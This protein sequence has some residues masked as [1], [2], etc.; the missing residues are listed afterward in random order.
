MN[1][2]FILCVG[3]LLRFFY[4]LFFHAWDHPHEPYR[5]LEPIAY[6]SRY[7]SG[8]ST[9][10]IWEWQKQILFW[11]PVY[12]GKT[13]V[14]FFSFFT[15]N[16]NVHFMLFKILL[17]FMSCF[18]IWVVYQWLIQRE[19][20]NTALLSAGMLAIFPTYIFQS[21]KLMDYNLEFFMTSFLFYCFW[22]IPARSRK[23]ILILLSCALWISFV[24]ITRIQSVF[25]LV[26]IWFGLIWSKQYKNAIAL[27][28]LSLLLVLLI[29]YVEHQLT[30]QGFLAPLWNNLKFHVLEHG[31]ETGWGVQKW[32][33]YFTDYFKYFGQ[34]IWLL[35]P[36]LALKEVRARLKKHTLPLSLFWVPFLFFSLLPHKEARFIFGADWVLVILFGIIASEVAQKNK[37]YRK[38]IIAFL[39]LSVFTS[40]YVVAQLENENS[41]YKIYEPLE[42]FNG[43]LNKK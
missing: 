10:L 9:P 3:F 32:H 2:R 26:P 35:L 6:L 1:I 28:V 42:F 40:G 23:S 34:A 11:F 43:P 39:V 14:T 19:Q 18:P 5:F 37:T 31:A 36:W 21:T 33:R 24:F 29:A 7:I 41:N 38:S 13:L 27:P 12:A 17:V 16:P 25:L 22:V 15:T 20:K 8:H 30:G 4:A